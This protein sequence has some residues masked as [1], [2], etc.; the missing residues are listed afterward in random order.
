MTSA[1]VKPDR[2]VLDTS[3]LLTLMENEAGADRVEELLLTGKVT[4]PWV[5]LMETYYITQQEVG[6]KAADYRYATVRQLG[7][8]VLEEVH[9]AILLTAARLKATHRMSFADT[10]VAAYA[11]HHDATL[12]HKDPEF[13]ALEGIASLEAL[14]YKTAASGG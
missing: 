13:E 1:D 8:E 3:A 5:V 4:L 11:L 14:P 7:I 12:V 10:L 9:E 2:F 6:Q